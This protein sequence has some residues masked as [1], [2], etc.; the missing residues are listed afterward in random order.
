MCGF[1]I[2]PWIINTL[3]LYLFLPIGFLIRPHTASTGK[4][5]WPIL[6]RQMNR[7]ILLLMIFN[8]Y[9]VFGQNVVEVKRIELSKEFNETA[10]KAV[11]YKDSSIYKKIENLENGLITSK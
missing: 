6:K 7:L 3:S 1:T 4:P 8:S 5:L 9:F 11:L 2:F 10:K